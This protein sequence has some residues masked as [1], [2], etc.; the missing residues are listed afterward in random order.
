MNQHSSSVKGQTYEQ[1][2]ALNTVLP[3]TVGS[4]GTQ[5]HYYMDWGQAGTATQLRLTGLKGLV[6]VGQVW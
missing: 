2:D 5:P 3:S 4:T 1:T 6:R